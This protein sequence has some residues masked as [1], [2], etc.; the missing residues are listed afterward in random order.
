MAR[1]VPTA[2]P[3]SDAERKQRLD[4]VEHYVSLQAQSSSMSAF[5][6]CLRTYLGGHAKDKTVDGEQA[7]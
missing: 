3:L 5:V 1:E 2:C 6:E 7:R 4:A